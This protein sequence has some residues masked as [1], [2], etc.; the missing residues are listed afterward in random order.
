MSG[1][2]SDAAMNSMHGGCTSLWCVALEIAWQHKGCQ[3]QRMPIMHHHCRAALQVRVYFSQPACG[4]MHLARVVAM[5]Y[6]VQDFESLPAEYMH[7]PEALFGIYD[8][9]Y[10]AMQEAL[11]P[12]STKNGYFHELLSGGFSQVRMAGV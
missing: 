6:R 8:I 3:L 9:C 2:N 7:Q 11:E 1:T 5:L 12:G 10:A 4:L